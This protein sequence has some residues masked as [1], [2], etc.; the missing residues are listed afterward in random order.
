MVKN[1]QT[2]CQQYHTNYLSVFD[3]FVGLAHKGLKLDSMTV[4]RSKFNGT[5]NKSLTNNDF[6]HIETSQLICMAKVESR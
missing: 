4:Y 5:L 2:M 1:T 6:H 3:H